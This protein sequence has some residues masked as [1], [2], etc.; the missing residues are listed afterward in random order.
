MNY[1]NIGKFIATS[2]KKK[3]LTQKELAN[4]LHITDRAVSKWERGKGCPDISLLEEL[5]NIL[6]VSIIELLKGKKINNKNNIE[7][8]EILYSINYV[9][10]S[11]RN[12]INNVINIIIITLIGIIIILIIFNNIK[13]NFLFNNKYYNNVTFVDSKNIFEQL[14]NNLNIINKQS[15]KF[16][17]LKQII[18]IINKY[19]DEDK[20]LYQK[21]YYTYSDMKKIILRDNAYSINKILNLSVNS[22][23]NN[24]INWNNDI[25]YFTNSYY[26]DEHIIKNFINNSYKY[27]Y[28]YNYEES[29]GNKVKNLIHYKYYIYS[30]IL[31]DIIN[32]GDINE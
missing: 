14:E 27:N 26:E 28:S 25:E 15:Y 32:D 12:K 9:N 23:Q 6:D 21:E 10:T 29:I 5:S 3:G 30:L 4:L 11:I 8:E 24:N 20:K 18:N 13:I 1:D 22:R 16:Q 31:E 7:K 17:E 2:R 19:I